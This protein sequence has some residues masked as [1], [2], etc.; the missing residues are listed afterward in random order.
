MKKTDNKHNFGDESEHFFNELDKKLKENHID[1]IDIDNFLAE[2][3]D[4]VIYEEEKNN[5]KER[6]FLTAYTKL[7]DEQ[8]ACT[9]YKI[10]EDSSAMQE[11][12]MFILR[13]SVFQYFLNMLT[14]NNFLK[15]KQ[16]NIE[17]NLA[18]LEQL[19]GFYV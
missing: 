6:I 19:W 11:L 13:Q 5:W 18:Y 17:D 1:E 15:Y 7:D 12:Y 16:Q 3:I 9:L 14:E 4:N 2:N 8:T 10:A